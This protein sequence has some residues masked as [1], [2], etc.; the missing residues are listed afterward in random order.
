M[1]ALRA[2]PELEPGSN[3]KAWVMT[4]AHRK[5]LDH[6]TARKRRPL[7]V[8]EVPE[9]R[10]TTTG[11]PRRRRDLVAGARAPAEAARRS[12]PAL[13]RRPHPRRGRDRARLQRGGRATV[14]PRGPQAAAR[15]DGGMKL[16][17]P[18]TGSDGRRGRR[19]PLRRA[20]RRRRRRRLRDHRLA[21]RRAGRLRRRGRDWSRCTSRADDGSG[22]DRRARTDRD[23]AVA[24]DPRGARALRRR[25]PRARRVLRPAGA[26]PSTIPIDWS[27]V[28]AV[29]PAHPPGAPRRS[30]SARRAPTARSPPPRATRRPRA[31]PGAR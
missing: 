27:L 23:Q 16:T 14:R 2:Y 19:G 18:A 5:A 28:T 15:G 30:A 11:Q 29:R 8:D 9:R 20:R 22:L 13:R 25:P 17:P 24:A 31:P 21:G 10:A 1:A 12:D 4:I 6:F 26:R 3:E 7:P